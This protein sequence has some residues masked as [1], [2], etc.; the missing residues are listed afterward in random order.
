MINFST[1]IKKGANFSPASLIYRYGKEKGIETINCYGNICFVIDGNVYGYHSYTIES[2]G[3][4]EKVTISMILK[5][6]A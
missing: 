2:Q 1:M 6:K 3:N 5:N 4:I